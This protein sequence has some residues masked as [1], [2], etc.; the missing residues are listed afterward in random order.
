MTMEIIDKETTI[1]HNNGKA[2]EESSRKPASEWT[3][4]S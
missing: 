1:I 4:P 2:S 3:L